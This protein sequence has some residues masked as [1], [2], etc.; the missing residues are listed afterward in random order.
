[1]SKF[2]SSSVTVPVTLDAAPADSASDIV[3]ADAR[4]RISDLLHREDWLAIWAAFLIIA[5]AAVGV[6]T[7]SFDFQGAKFAVWGTAEHPYP[8]QAFTAVIASRWVLTFLALGVVFTLAVGLQHKS[9]RRFVPAFV[10]LFLLTSLARLL[11]AQ[12]LFNRYLEYAFWALLLGLLVANVWRVPAWL[13]PA[14]QT[15]LYIKTGLVIMGAEVLFSNVARFGLY[16][17]GI[18]WGVTPIVILFMWF[19]GTRVLKIQNKSLVITMAAATSVCGT[20]AAI[21]AAAAS[22]ARRTDLTFAVGTSLIFTVIMMVGL[23]LLIRAVGLDSLIGGA[24]IGGTVDSTGAV[25]LA[26]QA[27]GD[28][29]GVVA[30]L[31]KMIQNVLIGFIAFGIAIFFTTRIDR[32]ADSHVG[33]GEIWQRFPKFILGFLAASLVFSFILQPTVGAEATSSVIAH[34]GQ[35]K[36][37]AFALAFTSI[38]LETNF[39]DLRSQMQGGKPVTLY[40]VGQLF[41]LIL[42]LV[43]CWLLLSGV[44]FPV[45]EIVL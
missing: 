37:W 10:A 3:T 6:L 13:R 39:G 18:A 11:S 36:N 9:V 34:L 42:T 40:L 21:A 12:E 17:L 8:W 35:F 25:V 38:G 24:W 45:P 43:V 5:V 20:S 27:L 29:G 44:L 28:L 33:A 7:G 4:F 14:L 15:E 32:R 30:A 16:G 31:V 41:N 23:P 1:M 19:F 22:R 2:T 26:G